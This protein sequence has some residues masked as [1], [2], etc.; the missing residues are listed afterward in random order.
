MKY[1]NTNVAT[2]YSQQTGVH[3]FRVAPSGS[4]DAAIS[5]TEAM[6]IDNSGRVT[7]PLNPAF[8]AR[9]DSGQTGNWN[10]EWFIPNNTTSVGCNVGSHYNTSNGR[11][12][13]PVAGSYF[14]SFGVRIDSRGGD[15][16]YIDLMKNGTMMHRQLTDEDNSYDNLFVAGV[17]AMAANDYVQAK[18]NTVG[19]TSS[20]V[21]DE[22]AFTGFLIG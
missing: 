4:A 16:F 5:W 1:I 20:T 10:G 14:F 21:S 22:S 9:Y 11:F 13:A 17:I 2:L 18:I 15:Y 12:Y 7:T 3:Y 8:A 6:K 19:D